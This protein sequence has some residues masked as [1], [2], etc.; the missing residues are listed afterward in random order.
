MPM[1]TKEEYSFLISLDDKWKW[2]ARDKNG[3]LYLFTKEPIKLTYS[4]VSWSN[5]KRSNMKFIS[6][7]RLFPFVRWSDDKATFIYDLIFDYKKY[8]TSIKEL[9]STRSVIARPIQENDQPD[10]AP[11]FEFVEKEIYGE[12]THKDSDVDDDF[13]RV[14]DSLNK[15]GD[16]N[17]EYRKNFVESL[18]QDGLSALKIRLGDKYSRMS[19]LLDEGRA[20]DHR[21]VKLLLEDLL[22]DVMLSIDYIMEKEEKGYD[23]E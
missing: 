18:D 23:D 7:E 21:P 5:A 16:K 4:F 2:L 3:E 8:S 9:E 15:F 11:E 22:E 12:R 13:K 14:K 10:E 20:I 1:I 19:D 17:K 6:D